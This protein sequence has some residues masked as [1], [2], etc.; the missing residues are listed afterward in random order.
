MQLIDLSHTIS[1]GMDQ[2]P[3]DPR[4]VRLVREAEHG[5]DPWMATVLELGC[6]VGTHIDAP[7][8]FRADGA[9]VDAL[10]LAACAGRA[11]VVDVRAWV[12]QRMIPDAA[13][14]ADGARDVEFLLLRTGWDDHWGTPRYYDEWPYLEPA[15]VARLAG[16]GLRGI[17]LDTPS[18]DPLGGDQAHVVAAAH[19]MI[20]LENVTNLATLPGTPFLLLALPLKLAGTEASPVRAVALTG[21]SAQIT[22][23]ERA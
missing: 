6:H 15:L 10:P 7:L 3:G 21:V 5:K 14:P 20:N 17:G 23:S 18:L 1:S 16:A 2:Y 12:A 19:G 13:V 4:P 22:E 11:R 9:A 8:H